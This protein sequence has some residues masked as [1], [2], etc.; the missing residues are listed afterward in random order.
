MPEP[1]YLEAEVAG[2]VED[3]QVGCGVEGQGVWVQGHPGEQTQLR[4]RAEVPVKNLDFRVDDSIG[5]SSDC[6]D[7]S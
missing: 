6:E 2:K 7:L 3:V 5:M 1:A 4:V